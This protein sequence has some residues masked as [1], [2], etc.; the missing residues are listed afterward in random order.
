MRC[1]KIS[2]PG[3]HDSSGCTTRTFYRLK[4]FVD[5]YNIALDIWTDGSKHYLT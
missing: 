4:S 2:H 3:S 1:T 5:Y